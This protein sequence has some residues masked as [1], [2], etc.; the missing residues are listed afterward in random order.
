MKNEINNQIPENQITE[1]RITE[2]QITEIQIPE[3][4]TIDELNRFL[5][6]KFEYG[7]DGM[8]VKDL[9][10]DYS[11]LRSA[12]LELYGRISEIFYKANEALTIVK[13]L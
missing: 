12:S 3:F 8:I 1:I 10:K 6:E 13:G 9:V 11:K 7:W 4:Q 5:S 2:K